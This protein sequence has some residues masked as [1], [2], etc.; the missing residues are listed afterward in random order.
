MSTIYS[1]RGFVIRKHKRPAKGTDGYTSST[2]AFGKDWERMVNIP[3]FIND[4]NH[5]M[6]GV[7]IADQFRSFFKVG[8]KCYRTWKPLFYFLLDISVINAFRLSHYCDPKLP[9]FKDRNK[10]LKFHM[11]LATQLMRRCE[12]PRKVRLL[13]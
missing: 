12:F 1:G 10:H 4:Y 9:H 11:R 7:D 8:R 13:Y 2:D 6:H 5:Y 3:D